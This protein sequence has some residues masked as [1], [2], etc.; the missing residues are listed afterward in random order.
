[1]IRFRDI[2]SFLRW[3]RA[4]LPEGTTV[5]FVPTMGY[6]HEGHT[7]L[8]DIAR[9]RCDALVVSNFVNPLQFGPH[10]DL[11]R[12]PRDPE[13]DA[14]KCERHGVDAILEARSLYPVGFQTEVRVGALGLRLCGAARPG[15]FS[16]VTTVVARLLGLVR[17]LFAVFGEKDYQQLLVVRRMVEDLAMNVEIL[18]GPIVRDPDGLALSSRNRFLT[19][20]QRRR[21]LSL[22]L[23]L[24]AMQDAETRDPR[25]LEA[26]GRSLLDVDALDYL[27]IVDTETLELAEDLNVPRRALV[28]ARVGS[29]RLIDN[30]LIDRVLI[31]RVL[32]DDVPINP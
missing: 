1:M 27:E 10:E 14:E 17:P 26:L 20:D 6:L 32:I 23:V 9:P 3:R 11:D 28:A 29:T 7:R 2:E 22:P 18:S 12:Y 8:M 16:G 15:H 13:G 19:A 31:D 30:V 5:G 21:A 4:S 25:A 24:R